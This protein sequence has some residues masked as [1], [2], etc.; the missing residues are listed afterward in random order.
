MILYLSE[1][2]IK[3]KSFEDCKPVGLRLKME[4]GHFLKLSSHYDVKRSAASNENLCRQTSFEN[5]CKPTVEPT[6]VTLTKHFS[7]E[8][9]TNMANIRL[10]LGVWV[11]NFL[12]RTL[13]RFGNN[14]IIGFKSTRGGLFAVDLVLRHAEF[15]M[16]TTQ[17]DGQPTIFQCSTKVLLTIP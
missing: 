17:W 12:T 16:M 15:L 6:K 8:Y 10:W 14:S 13:D 1:E 5:R 9:S 4:R 11:H 7:C 2:A 3:L